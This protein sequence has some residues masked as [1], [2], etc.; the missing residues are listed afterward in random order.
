[1]RRSSAWWF[2]E[3]GLKAYKARSPRMTPDLAL[4]NRAETAVRTA[5]EHGDAAVNRRAAVIASRKVPGVH[6][7]HLLRAT[8]RRQSRFSS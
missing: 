2:R 1:M 6:E 7:T 8:A 3:S 4:H 5:A